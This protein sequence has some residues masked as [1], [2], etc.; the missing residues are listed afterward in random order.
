MREEIDSN[1]IT[2]GDFNTYLHQ[3]ID[4]P[5]RKSTRKQWL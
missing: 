2:A 5:D 4:H 1:A 3:W